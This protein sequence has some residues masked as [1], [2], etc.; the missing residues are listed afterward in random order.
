MEQGRA[1]NNCN[2]FFGGFKYKSEVISITTMIGSKNS[3]D[4]SLGRRPTS[5][6]VE[7]LLPIIV[8]LEIMRC[9]KVDFSKKCCSYWRRDPPPLPP[10][11]FGRSKGQRSWVNVQCSIFPGMGESGESR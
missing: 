10:G 6:S 11:V 9:Q 2:T 5:K 8:V 1:A 7:F 3:S 4:L